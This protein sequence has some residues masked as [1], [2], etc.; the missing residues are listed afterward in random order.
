LK[1]LVALALVACSS[2][3]G[4]ISFYERGAQPAPAVTS[5]PDGGGAP[6]ASA[7]PFFGTDP[8]AAGQKGTKD[9]TQST[10]HP[11]GNP[12]IDCQQCHD[13]NGTAPKWIASGTVYTSK[14]GTSAVAE[15][16][17]VR[18]NDASGKK[19]ASVYTDKVGNFVFDT[20]ALPAGIPSG[21]H[22]AVRNAQT[23]NAMS[24]TPGGGC[25]ATSCHAQ[26]SP[27]GRVSAAP[28]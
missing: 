12:G 11:N 2:E 28:N 7:D 10:T 25:N 27:F 18:I 15:G 19:I 1:R 8:F 22:V 5:T 24:G 4:H 14:A 9:S 21:A 16:A 17:E 3:P 6:P 20:T 26:G 23:T 13:G